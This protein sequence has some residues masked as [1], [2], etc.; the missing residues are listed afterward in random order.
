[1]IGQTLG[2]YRITGKIGEGG[3]GTVWRARDTL[4]GRTVALKLLSDS[5]QGSEKAR[6]RF[7]HE[8][9]AAASLD[10]P[11][12]VAVYDAGEAEGRA[13]IALAIVD[14]E[15]LSELAARRLMPI[16]EA[17]RIVCEACAALGHA[18]ERGVVHRDV[19]ARNIMVA[20]DGRVVVLDF[21]LALTRGASRVTSSETAIGTAAYMAPEAVQGLELDARA[22]V[23]GLGVVLYEALTGTQPFAGERPEAMLF[24]ILNL[25]PRPPR[26]LRPDIPPALERIVL[27]AIARDRNDRYPSA[28]ALLEDLRTLDLAG[29]EGST[30]APHTPADESNLPPGLEPPAPRPIAPTAGVSDNETGGP[31]LHAHAARPHPLFLALLP[32]EASKQTD[33]PEPAA[34]AFAGRIAGTLSAALAGAGGVHVIPPSDRPLPPELRDTRSIARALGANALLRGT[35]ARRG[36]QLRVTWAMV[37]A[38]GGV[39][40]AGDVVDGSIV[41]PFDLEDGVVASVR[42]ALGIEVAP[43][44]GRPASRPPDPAAEDRFI[45]AQRYLQRYDQETSVDGAIGLLEQLMTSEGD[46][47]LRC[48][49]LSRAYLAKYQLTRQRVWEGRAAAACDRATRL[50]ADLP[51]VLAAVGDLH[52]NAGNYA[53]AIMDYRRA[54]GF[55]PELFE[56]MLGLARALEASGQ[57]AEAEATCRRAIEMKPDDWRGYSWMGVIHFNHGDHARALTS[58]HRVIE[59]TPDNVRGHRNLGSA[60]F[61]MDRIEDALSAYRASLEI[62]PNDTAYTNIGTALYLLGRY[63]EAIAAFEKAIALNPTNPLWWGNLGNACRWIPGQA[64]RSS[65]ALQQAIGLMQDHLFRNPSDADGRARLAGWLASQGNDRAALIEIRSALES[66]PSD[67]QVMVAAGHVY[68]ETGQRA[69]ALRW[70][71]EA[72]R[73]GYGPGALERDPTFAPLRSDPEFLRLLQE[74]P[75]RVGR[76]SKGESELGRSA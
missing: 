46:S 53:E 48:A 58:W 65:V 61:R 3:I 12:I 13:Y 68:F 17:V 76:Q 49:T 42:G 20:R 23:Y 19:T 72:L 34:T 74:S 1:M 71:R 26:G 59:L 37:N 2:R 24:A 57:K 18:H 16:P 4:L 14:G 55:K 29:L 64:P 25:P 60:F 21:G 11:G 47:A 9:Q 73:H 10:H 45:Q 36:T 41:Q 70:L 38:S 40:F 32:F 69:E 67:A 27:K 28:E 63:E 31:D 43:A 30:P 52:F 51:E 39:Q 33:D 66:A 7:L 44:G 54:L 8:G 15:T 50:N 56:A 22:D 75:T 35:V 5:F 62:Q 6:R